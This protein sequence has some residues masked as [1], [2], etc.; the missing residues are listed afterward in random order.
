MEKDGKG[1]CWQQTIENSATLTNQQI[2]EVFN[3]VNWIHLVR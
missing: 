2:G 1:E 3:L